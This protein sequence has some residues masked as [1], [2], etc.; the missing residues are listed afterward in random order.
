[1][2]DLR[3]KVVDDTVFDV[4]APENESPGTVEYGLFECP[5][6]CL[7]GGVNLL[8][9]RTEVTTSLPLIGFGPRA[10]QRLRL[11]QPGVTE[12]ITIEDS[13]WMYFREHDG[14]VRISTSRFTSGGDVPVREALAAFER[15]VEEI[16]ALISARVPRMTR[17]PQWGYWFPD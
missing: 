4:E 16:K 5:V 11:L 14:L 8:G 15:F 13:G 2:I 17:H 3:F 6:Y 9:I 12:Q 7:V 1:M 10:L